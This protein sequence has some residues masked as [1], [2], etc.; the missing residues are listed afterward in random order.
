MNYEK[1]SARVSAIMERHS[2]G[3][4]RMLV[5]RFRERSRWQRIELFR[6]YFNL[7]AGMRMLDLGGGDGSHVSA[8]I[9][10][11]SINRSD[12]FVADIDEPA[13]EIARSRYGHTPV[14][15]R[16]DERQLPFPDGHFD[17]VFCS[18]V[19]EHVTVPK[20]EMWEITDDALFRRQAVASQAA[21]ANEIRRLGR[22]YY[23]Q[24]PYRYF[25]V[26][27]HSWLP[28]VAQIPRKWQI[29]VIKLANRYWIKQTI[30]DFH[31]PTE[32]EMRSYFP[33]AT[34][35][36]EK[37]FRLRKSMIAIRTG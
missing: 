13:L 28:L 21:M 2:S 35:L 1:P 12:V 31:L 23:V 36:F 20:S 19:L 30:P 14:M 8:L 15:L 25:P 3:V 10:G 18:S 33:D 17:L 34:L 9:H 26:E 37:M 22:R 7:Q 27:T 5:N 29:R 4:V 11:S 32:E 24:V 6:R 16:E